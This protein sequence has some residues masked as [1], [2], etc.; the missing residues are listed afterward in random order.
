MTKDLAICRRCKSTKDAPRQ[1][2]TAL[3][4]KCEAET[5]C[6]H[7]THKGG[8]RSFNHVCGAGLRYGD[9]VGDE[10]AGSG[11]RCPCHYGLGSPEKVTCLK[12]EPITEDECRADDEAFEKIIQRKELF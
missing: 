8:L 1:N 11:L 4:V 3:C 5:S 10:I 6:R 2:S 7:D 9:V 12:F